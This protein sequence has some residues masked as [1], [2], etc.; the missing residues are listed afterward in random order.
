MVVPVN[1]D[2]RISGVGFGPGVASPNCSVASRG[3]GRPASRPAH[4]GRG[5]ASF[6]APPIRATVMAEGEVS[7]AG[8]PFVRPVR[9]T[10]PVRP[11]R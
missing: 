9:P 3:V 8:A 5:R 1:R 10:T 4:P 2:A 11:R 6:C 7:P